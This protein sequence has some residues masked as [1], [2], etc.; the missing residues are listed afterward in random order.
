MKN[1]YL[2]TCIYIYHLDNHSDFGQRAS[3]FFEDAEKQKIQIIASPLILH[4]IMSGIYKYSSDIAEEIYALLIS[5]PGI[6]WV[7]YSI[8]IADLSA[9]VRARLNLKTP[10]AIHLATALKEKCLSFVTNDVSLKAR[11]TL[12]DLKMIL[13]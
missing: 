12:L 4:E 7:D 5:H 10:D 3:K 13:I 8:E 9:S 11:E 2:D 6:Q 1:V